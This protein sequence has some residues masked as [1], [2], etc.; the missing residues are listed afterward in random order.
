MTYLI[1]H[2]GFQIED[3][4]EKRSVFLIFYSLL[5]TFLAFSLTFDKYLQQRDS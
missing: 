2:L 4:E 3:L 5:F 1:K